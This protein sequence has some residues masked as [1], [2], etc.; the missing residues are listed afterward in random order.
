MDMGVIGHIAVAL[1]LALAVWGPAP[2]GNPTVA[3]EPRGDQTLVAVADIRRCRIV[4]NTKAVP[5][6]DWEW[7]CSTVVHEWGH[8]TGHNH[9]PDPYNVM[10]AN[11]IEPYWRCGYTWRETR[12]P[13]RR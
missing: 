3:Y 5:R 4:F 11:A 9:S 13:R 1:H 12:P 7:A 6:P 10:N 8:L 2:C